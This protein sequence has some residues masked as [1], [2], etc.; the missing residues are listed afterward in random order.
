MALDNLSERDKAVLRS[1]FDPTV[2]IAAD[3]VE[4]VKDQFVEDDEPA[5]DDYKE[6]AA[7]CAEG[8]RLAESGKL[9]EALETMT[10][11]VQAAP[12]RAAAYN[13][14]AQLLR[15]MQKDDEATADIDRA[16]S[17]TVGKKTRARA[18]ALCQRGVLL[19]KRGADDDARAAFTEAAKLGSSFAKK[20]VVEL[21]PYAALCNQM[22][23]QVMRGEKDIKL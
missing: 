16:L 4:D 15:L 3:V 11:G 18:L 10:R 2:T 6:S 8:V 1:I 23:S 21:N 17:L 13:D 22:L 12:E 19:R 9:A 5:T 14:R 7:L 20:Q